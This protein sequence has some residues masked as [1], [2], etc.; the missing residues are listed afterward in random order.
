[1][2][3]EDKVAIVTGAARGIGRAIALRLAAEG[4]NVAV[5]D[6]DAENAKKTAGEIEQLGRKSMAVSANVSDPEDVQKAVKY[7]LDKLEVV[8]ILVNNA[9]I[10]MDAL[11]VRMKDAQWQ[12]VLD[13][14]LTG[15]FNWTRACARPMMKQKSGRIVNMASV[16]GIV[17]NTGQANYSASKAGVIGLTKSA[18]RELAPWNINVNAVAPGFI[19]TRMT[20]RL[21]EKV[22]KEILG[23]IP[24]SRWGG[25]EE[26]ADVVLFL[27]S[28]YSAY[29]TGQVINVD[30]GMV[31]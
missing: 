12:D 18:A 20:E 1:M 19:D 29:V 9:G 4:A 17:G 21:P 31:M 5:S 22:K 10:A 30:G 24:M 2:L 25:P 6:V 3:L 13:V 16:I 14:N 28:R 8:N 27:D 15:A 7:C 23:S 26:V 11:L